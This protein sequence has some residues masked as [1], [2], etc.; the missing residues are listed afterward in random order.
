MHIA[1]LPLAT[2]SARLWLHVVLILQVSLAGGSK[3]LKLPIKG[4][5]LAPKLAVEPQG[6][7]HFGIVPT[8]EWADQLL[9]L[10]NSCSEL[11]MRVKVDRSGP[12]FSAEPSELQLPP[13]ATASVL[14]RYQPKVTADRTIP[15]SH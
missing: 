9:Q 12:Y 6:T 15:F 14:L 7:L 8:Y 4:T 3:S 2:L 13:D 5:G 10:A 1:T 11:P